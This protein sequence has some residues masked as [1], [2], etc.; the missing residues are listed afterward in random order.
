MNNQLIPIL[1]A[2]DDN[3]VKYL[4]VAILSM[5][6]N[7]K[8]ET[9]Y[10]IHIM[11]PKLYNKHILN[12]F[13]KLQEKFSNIKINYIVVGNIFNNSLDKKRI[14]PSPT[15][16]YLKIADIFQQYD[17]A[18]YLDPDII[19]LEDL[20]D[21]FN[22]DLADNYVAGVKAATYMDGSDDKYYKSIGLNDLSQYIN[23]NSLVF[24]LKLIRENNITDKFCEY[25][26]NIYSSMDQD[27]LNIVCY[28][29]IKHI[30]IKYN[31]MVKY[32][33]FN[34]NK[35]WSYEFLKNIYG[36]FNLQ[37]AENK[38]AIIHYANVKSKPWLVNTELD[39]Y[40][41]KYAGMTPY[42]N[43]FLV[44][45]N[46]NKTKLLIKKIIEN[47]FSVTNKYDK[48]KNKTK[49]ITIFGFKMFIKI[50]GSRA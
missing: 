23:A 46:L 18:L 41:W 2:S 10:D 31:L 40:W 20:S 14:L 38:P 9:I 29:K 50:K 47:C 28:G 27:V 13:K 34:N 39:N 5:L 19:V 21:L 4:Y 33:P 37:D 43:S 6:E 48:N 11:C 22:I 7:K 24:N 26:K 45:Y 30:P 44:K 3:Y 42:Y 16:Y 15:Y 35:K 12:E 1:F 8:S 49:I 25:S 17:K 36:E 32:L